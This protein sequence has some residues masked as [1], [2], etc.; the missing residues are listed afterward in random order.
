MENP[1]AVLT[2]RL[3]SGMCHEPVSPQAHDLK[4]AAWKEANGDLTA[5]G[6]RRKKREE[7]E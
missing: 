6:R 2:V 3:W 1:L 4:I 7:W 5:R